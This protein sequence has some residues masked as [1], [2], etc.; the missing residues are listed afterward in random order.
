VSVEVLRELSA[1]GGREEFVVGHA[2]PE[3]VA[4][5]RGELILVE[6]ARVDL[7]R[8]IVEFGAE[9]KFRAGEDR[10]DG[11]LH[12]GFP[13]L[14]A[15]FDFG[16]QFCEAIDFGFRGRATKGARG[17]AG[18]NFASAGDGFGRIY[19]VDEA[20]HAV[21]AR[22]DGAVEREFANEELGFGR[23]VGGGSGVAGEE[24]EAD[25]FEAGDRLDGSF[26]DLRL[27]RVARGDF[28]RFQNADL[29]VPLQVAVDLLQLF[30]RRGL[31]HVLAGGEDGDTDRELVGSLGV[32]LD[33]EAVLVVLQNAIIAVERAGL[34]GV[35]RRLRAEDAELAGKGLLAGGIFLAEIDSLARRL[36]DFQQH[37]LL[38]DLFGRGEVAFHE[39]RRHRED[40]ADVVEAVADVVG[41]EVFRR[42]GVETVEEVADRVIVFDAI[43]P[44][45]G[46]AAGIGSGVAIVVCE[47]FSH[48]RCE[49]LSLGGRRLRAI[50]GRHRL[51]LDHLDEVLPRFALAEDI[52]RALHGG[53]REAGFR[54]VAR[55]AGGA[56]LG[57]EA[58]ER[59]RGAGMGFGRGGF[60]G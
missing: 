52:V 17:E 39:D 49:L 7:G 10:L 9:E 23:A 29:A 16:D 27:L 53:E 58:L 8:T 44:T 43:Q 57:E 19:I 35:F 3:E 34:R 32:A 20:T 6:R 60:C 30:G 51:R 41:G 18:E 48:G 26:E 31:G 13:L 40:V 11:E 45:H 50:I 21:R 24:R 33:F 59:D 46:D 55:V 5:P 38:G 22:I 42:V 15:G 12:P 28:E 1:R 54:V 2:A 14:A 56:M 4:E 36:G 25:A 47:D 37:D